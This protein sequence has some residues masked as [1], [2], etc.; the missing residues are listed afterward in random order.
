MPGGKVA[1]FKS[2]IRKKRIVIDA[3][4]ALL[5]KPLDQEALGSVI[6]YHGWS[7]QKENHDV[8]A[9]S[10]CASG[11]EVLVPDGLYHGERGVLDYE[12]DYDKLPQVILKSVE[13]FPKLYAYLKPSSLALTGHSMGSMIAAA[14]FHRETWVDKAVVINGYCDFGE[15][16]KGWED[17]T[18]ELLKLDPVK[19]LDRVGERKLLILHGDADTSVSIDVQRKYVQ[20]AKASFK[21]GHL[22]YEEIPNLNHYI[23]LSMLGR[24]LEFLQHGF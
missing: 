18:Q 16:F 2:R 15:G 4:P 23:T 19:F 3:I 20:K 8:M 24:T 14:L 21:E 13:E 12:K 22:L 9:S 1:M 10:L 7:S 5:Y 11:Y 17:L 6:H